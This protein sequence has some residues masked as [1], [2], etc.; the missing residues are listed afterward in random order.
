VFP[1]AALQALK[2][3]PRVDL[4]ALRVPEL[5]VLRTGPAVRVDEPGRKWMGY[6]CKEL[7][8]DQILPA[9]DRWW[10]CDPERVAAGLLLPVTVCEFV[11]AVLVGLD[12]WVDNG[13]PATMRRF[14]FNR[15]RLAGYVIDLTS[16]SGHVLLP[17]IDDEDQKLA[18]QLLGSR[19]PSQSGGPIAYVPAGPAVVHEG[20]S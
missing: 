6:S 7:E 8:R 11:V 16:T 9:L 10:R 13:E 5:A 20:E 19:L 1:L 14:H 17:G 4:S 18:A 3:A 2:A 12:G 15:A